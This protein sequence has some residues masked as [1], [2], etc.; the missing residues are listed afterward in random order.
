MYLSAE[1]VIASAIYQVILGLQYLHGR[2]LIHCDIKPEVVQSTYTR[3]T[4]YP[5]TDIYTVE[6]SSI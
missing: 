3:E 2:F 4:V 5:N 1:R 6:H